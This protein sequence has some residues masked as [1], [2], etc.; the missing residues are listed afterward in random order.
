MYSTLKPWKRLNYTI[1]SFKAI[2]SSFL[3]KK[4]I[5]MNKNERVNIDIENSPLLKSILIY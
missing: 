3:I 1:K 4:K 2:H 5:N